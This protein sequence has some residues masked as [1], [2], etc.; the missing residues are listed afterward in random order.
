MGSR[1]GLPAGL[2]RAKVLV[3]LGFHQILAWGSSYYLL[4]VLAAPISQDTGWDLTWVTAGFSIGLVSSGVVS[5]MVGRGVVRFGG[6]RVLAVGSLVLALGLAGLALAPTLPFYLLAWVVLGAGMGAS[7][8]DAAFSTLG[9]LY[10]SSARGTITALTLFG[11]FASTVCWPLSALLVENIGWRGA[12]LTYAAAH[13]VYSVPVLLFALPRRSVL[14]NADDAEASTPA[15]GQGP[16]DRHALLLLMSIF[17]SG[18]AVFAIMSVHLLTFLQAFGLSLAAA[19]AV[20]ALVGPSQ[21]GAR[22]IEILVGRHHH[23]VWTLAMAAFLICLGIALLS[24]GLVLPAVCL[25]LYG[26]GN[27]IWSITR[28]T[29]PLA[30]F[31]A[32]DFP[33]ILGTLAKAAFL[34]QAAAPLLGAFAITRFGAHATLIGVTALTVLNVVLIAVLVERHR[35]TVR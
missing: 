2:E 21:V 30:L 14:A 26:A 3:P 13:L 19:V 11:G 27:G 12:C 17:V 8:Y 33:R 10:G 24:F 4:T 1:G 20:G 23:P 32:A 25:M 15:A 34:S 6:S 9:N 18:G 28:G 5:P 7:L 22:V 35:S 16:P 29:V 31:G